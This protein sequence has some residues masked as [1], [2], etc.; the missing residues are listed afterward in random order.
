MFSPDGWTAARPFVAS[1][2]AQPVE[3]ESA[4][5][6]EEWLSADFCFEG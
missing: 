3:L 6:A 5:C 4:E 1:L 2:S